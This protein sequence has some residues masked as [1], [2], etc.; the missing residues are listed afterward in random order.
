MRIRRIELPPFREPTAPPL[1][2]TFDPALP[3]LTAP[4]LE[5]EAGAAFSIDIAGDAGVITGTVEAG[6]GTLIMAPLVP[7]WT[8]ERQVRIEVMPRP[9][10]GFT[11]VSSIGGG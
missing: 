1:V 11:V 9:P 5:G 10:A 3:D 8:R 7:A 4:V 6:A 2:L